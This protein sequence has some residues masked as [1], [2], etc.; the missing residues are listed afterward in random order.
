M[1]PLK[2]PYCRDAQFYIGRGKEESALLCINAPEHLIF[3]EE[4]AMEFFDSP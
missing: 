4:G 1:G 2:C 3:G